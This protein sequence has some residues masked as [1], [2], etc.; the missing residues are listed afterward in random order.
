MMHARTIVM[1]LVG[2]WL[3]VLPGCQTGPTHLAPIDMTYGAPWR[4]MELRGDTVS[5]GPGVTLE[6]YA[7][8]RVRGYGGV[9]HFH[10]VVRSNGPGEMVFGDLAS[11]RRG[12]PPELMDLEQRYLQALGE[13]DRFRVSDVKLELLR[14]QTVVAKFVR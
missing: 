11:T 6:L 7:G 5:L 14:G 4:L 10:G 1:G 13:V 8:G 9:N 3:L 12:G 2:V